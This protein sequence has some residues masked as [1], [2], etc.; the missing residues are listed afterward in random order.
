M[1]TEDFG[2]RCEEK[3]KVE[4]QHLSVPEPR[5]A[6][7]AAAELCKRCQNY[8]DPAACSQPVSCSRKK[9]IYE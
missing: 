6:P 7:P 8:S 5:E 3:E 1:Y 2:N 4:I 9:C